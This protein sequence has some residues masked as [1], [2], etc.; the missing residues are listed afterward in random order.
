MYVHTN[1]GPYNMFQSGNP[2]TTFQISERTYNSV[3]TDPYGV[4]GSGFSIVKICRRDSYVFR[5]T[6]VVLGEPCP[7]LQKTIVTINANSFFQSCGLLSSYNGRCNML[8][9]IH[10]QQM[11]WNG[12]VCATIHKAMYWNLDI[13]F[14]ITPVRTSSI[15]PVTAV[16]TLA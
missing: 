1:Y 16:A 8:R 4:D 5:W 15:Q 6:G 14:F 2:Y 13:T 3:H 7:A 12:A 11:N 10:F 9:A